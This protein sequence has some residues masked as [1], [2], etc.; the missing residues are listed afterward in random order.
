MAGMPQ[1]PRT[2]FEVR[3]TVSRNWNLSVI[4]R[5]ELCGMSEPVVEVHVRALA[6]ASG[7]CAVF[8]G[9]EQKV[10]L[11]LVDRDAGAAIAMFMQ[12]AP[13]ERPLTHDLIANALRGLGAK[14]ERVMI[15]GLKQEAYL[16][17]LIVSAENE[18][19]PKKLIELEAQPSDGI[20]LALQ[21]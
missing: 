19:Q 8:L 9:N 2:L 7:G 12:R 1:N 16:A 10:F 5:G 20:A 18:V 13:K 17:R 6:A 11:M 4:S 3:L 15:S 21:P 14:I